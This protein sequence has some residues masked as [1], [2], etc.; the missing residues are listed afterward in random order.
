M[1]A[2]RVGMAPTKLKSFTPKSVLRN[3]YIFLG[4]LENLK[5]AGLCCQAKLVVSF[6]F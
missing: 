6:F 2:G 5:N 4:I 3:V 1:K